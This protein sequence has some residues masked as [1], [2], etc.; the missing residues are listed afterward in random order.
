M[1]RR[2]LRQPWLS[3]AA[4]RHGAPQKCPLTVKLTPPAVRVPAWASLHVGC[5]APRPLDG[6]ATTQPVPV[7]P[8]VAELDAV[9]VLVPAAEIGLNAAVTPGG[10]PDAV[11]VTGA[12]N[13]PVRL[14]VIVA[15]ARS[16][17]A[18]RLPG[19]TGRTCATTGRTGATMMFLFWF[20][21]RIRSTR[22]G[23]SLAV[24]L[25]DGLIRDV[26]GALSWRLERMHSI[27]GSA[28]IAGKFR[29]P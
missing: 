24:T 9:T 4:E 3:S 19:L 1:A 16:P 13:P 22:A 7:R 5:S 10:T 26:M 25:R 21:A 2:R 23:R 6:A 27:D 15:V 18:V 29:T 12:E 14:I 11:S 17:H 28:L 20:C 8:G